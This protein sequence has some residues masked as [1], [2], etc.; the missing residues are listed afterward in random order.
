MCFFFLSEVTYVGQRKT[1][2]DYDHFASLYKIGD[3]AFVE[4][5]TKRN[6]RAGRDTNINVGA[7][8]YEKLDA[9]RNK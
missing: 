5:L 6:R 2:L 1:Y 8:N 9:L 7:N 4:V 3:K